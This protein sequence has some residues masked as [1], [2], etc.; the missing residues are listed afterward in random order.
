MWNKYSIKVAENQKLRFHKIDKYFPKNVELEILP[1]SVTRISKKL[2]TRETAF[3][4]SQKFRITQREHIPHVIRWFPLF[5]AASKSGSDLH[6]SAATRWKPEISFI[7]KRYRVLGVIY[8]LL[9][10]RSTAGSISILFF[11]GHTH[12]HGGWI[13]TKMFAKSRRYV[14]RKTLLLKNDTTGLSLLAGRRW[15]LNKSNSA[16]LLYDL[17]YLRSERNHEQR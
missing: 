11:H 4:A 12:E 17:F 14:E 8:Y 15:C 5:P 3:Y 16:L 9:F 6:S 1:A 13:R 10:D 7:Y 2:F